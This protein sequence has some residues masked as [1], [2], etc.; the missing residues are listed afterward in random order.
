MEIYIC[1][2]I[3]TDLLMVAMIMHVLTYSGFNKAQ[4]TWYT[5]T[6]LA[7]IICSACELAVHCGYYRPSYALPLTV[8]TVL[9][10]SLSPTLA[11]LFSGALGLHEQAR[12][13][14]WFFLI[15]LVA[16]VYFAPT[17]LIFHFDAQGYHR[18][19]LFF[20]YEILYILGM[21]YLVGSLILVGRKFHQRDRLTIIMIMV[22]LLGGILPMT[23]FKIN[24]AYVAIGISACLSYIYYN[25]LT[26]QDI[27]EELISNQQRISEMQAHII[28]GLSSLIENRD[29][30]T[31]AH[32]ARTREYVRILAEHAR[33]DGVYADQIDSHFI[34]LLYTLSPLHDVGKIVVSDQ[35]LKKPG[36]LTSE[37]FEQIKR[38]AAVGGSV[39]RQI[40]GGITDEEHNSFA[41]DIATYHHEYWDGSGYPAHLAGEQIPLCARIMAI[42]DVFD[43][44]ISKRCYKNA[45]E[46]E[47]AFRIIQEESGTHFDPRLVEVF[48]R[49]R[50]DF[51]PQ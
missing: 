18:G 33:M 39:V 22:V 44:L 50:E 3:L 14:S 12:Q 48:L 51:L 15:S 20:L 17:G 2:I 9:Q 24:V 46:P 43:A 10:F 40:L 30:E 49:H 32:V 8:L 42:A 29:T 37:E 31:G 4:K 25:D 27:R 6:F 19:E 5:L 1:S 38:H 13:A 36:R 7:I 16:E 21:I 47:E 23:L 34:D 26:Q 11:V 35:I 28:S 41:S 45:M